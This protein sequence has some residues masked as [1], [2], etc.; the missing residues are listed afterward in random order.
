MWNTC[1]LLPRSC[2]R[3]RNPDELAASLRKAPLPRLIDHSTVRGVI[4]GVT[5]SLCAAKRCSI[6][7][8]AG[9]L[10]QTSHGVSRPDLRVPWPG[11]GEHQTMFIAGSAQLSC[12]L[13]VPHLHCQAT[14]AWWLWCQH[15]W[16]RPL[17]CASRHNCL[18][19]VSRCDLT[20]CLCHCST[21]KP[22]GCGGMRQSRR[23]PHAC[24][25]GFWRRR[26]S[27]RSSR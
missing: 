6:E 14:N 12:S 26:R 9:H 4:S 23:R 22:A 10:Q 15:C 8:F 21:G 16:H 1:C 20:G 7:R 24:R 5:A 17:L 3:A 18:L 2:R 19:H 27:Q 11:S 13:A 25:S